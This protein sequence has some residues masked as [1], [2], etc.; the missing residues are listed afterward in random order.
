MR[1]IRRLWCVAAIVLVACKRGG[2]AREATAVPH[3]TPPLTYSVAD[4]YHNTRFRGISWSADGGTA[5]ASTILVCPRWNPM[6]SWRPP[7]RLACRSYVLF[8]D[9]GHGFVKKDNEIKGYTAV[10]A[11]LDTHLKRRAAATR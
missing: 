5:R 4:V 3:V 2:S 10:I 9:E 7:G 6:R 11:F 1:L 8:P